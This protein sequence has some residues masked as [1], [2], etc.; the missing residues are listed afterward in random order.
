[1]IESKILGGTILEN[2]ILDVN[3]T[4]VG[5]ITCYIATWDSDQGGIYG[6]PDQFV[7]GAFLESLQEHRERGNRQIRMRYMHHHTI[8]GFPISRAYEDER[9]L[10]AVGHVNLD[11]QHGREAWA[12]IKQGVLTDMSIGF[13]AED[14]AISEGVRLIRK[15]KI[16]E[17]SIVDEPANRRAN[18]LESKR[19]V[20][21]QDLPLASKDREWNS[22]AAIGRIRSLTNSEDSPTSAYKTAFLWYD[23]Q[24]PGDFGSY[25]LPIADEIEG[26]LTA[27][28]RAIFAAAAALRGARGGV[29][30]PDADRASVIRS[31]ERYYG[32]LGMDSPFDSE[33]RR[34]V[35]VSELK[36]M[37]SQDVEEALRSGMAFS[38]AAARMML[39]DHGPQREPE[40]CYSAELKSICE[41]LRETI[42][43]VRSR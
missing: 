22:S 3:G 38:K 8:G 10:Y 43:A 1:M 24:E 16:Y 17:G 42:A 40:E 30:I 33:E 2:K 12:L 35:G 4:R 15:A 19:A 6:M 13:T 29:S 21:Y 32:K 7:R 36:R 41:T 31:I 25:K 11:T 14:D 34:F 39:A 23:E 18:I 20:P 28:P 26:K 5:E 37:S 9:G 27:V